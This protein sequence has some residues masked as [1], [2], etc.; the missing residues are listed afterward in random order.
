MQSGKLPHA[1]AAALFLCAACAFDQ[2][3]LERVPAG[4][5]PAL[6]DAAAPAADAESGAADAASGLSDAAPVVPDAGVETPPPDARPVT[7]VECGPDTC[8]W[9]EVCCATG[10]G[11]GG[12]VEIECTA[13]EDCPQRD[14]VTCDGPED[15]LGPDEVCCR[16][17]LLDNGT[18]CEPATSCFVH[19]C[20]TPDDCPA[21]NSQCCGSEDGVGSCST[22]GCL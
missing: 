15:C 6:P 22:I 4:E 10:G 19:A 3:G 18:S 7:E 20:R 8:T 11:M 21:A 12:D 5:G 13:A 2:G 17:S 1:F 16:T 9:P 14:S